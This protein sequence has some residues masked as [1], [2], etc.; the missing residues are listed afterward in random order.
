MTGDLKAEGDCAALP[1]SGSI[2]GG[3][4]LANGAETVVLD[5]GVSEQ[6]Y[7]AIAENDRWPS[8]LPECD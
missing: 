8:G 1:V 7:L 3:G 4:T 6:C 5:V 2:S